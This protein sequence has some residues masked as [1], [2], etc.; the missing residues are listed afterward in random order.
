MSIIACKMLALGELCINTWSGSG[1]HWVRAHGWPRDTTP[2]IVGQTSHA[3]C[4]LWNRLIKCK[5]TDQHF[6]HLVFDLINEGMVTNVGECVTYLPSILPHVCLT[7]HDS[8]DIVIQ[9]P[10]KKKKKKDRT[11]V[12]QINA[13]LGKPKETI[14]DL[15]INFFGLHLFNA[16]NHTSTSD[17]RMRP[18]TGEQHEHKKSPPVQI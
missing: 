15:L 16:E 13:T 8:P 12:I 14:S 3:P 4:C 6:G 11:Q 17:R 7:S 10:S 5:Q 9:S 2:D 1:R 18:W